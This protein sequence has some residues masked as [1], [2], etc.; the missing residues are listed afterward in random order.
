MLVITIRSPLPA[1]I[2]SDG[3]GFLQVPRALVPRRLRDYQPRISEKGVTTVPRPPPAGQE[4]QTGG[5]GEG[6]GKGLRSR[7]RAPA[8][9][10]PGRLRA[11]RLGPSGREP[12]GSSPGAGRATAGRTWPARDARIRSR[13]LAL[14]LGTLEPAVRCEG[15]GT[16]GGAP[17]P[18]RDC[19]SPNRETGRPDARRGV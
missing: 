17:G 9:E 15:T 18:S 19:G 10:A 14:G 13:G 8:G 12:A 5:P 1:R 7:G 16:D 2:K 11:P 6:G 4:R 3:S